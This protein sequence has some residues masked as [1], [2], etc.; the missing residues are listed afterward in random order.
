[1][2]KAKFVKRSKKFAL[3]IAF[4]LGCNVLS[5]G[6]M[7]NVEA[8][9]QITQITEET[10][11]FTEDTTVTTVAPE[12]SAVW[13]SI[14]SVYSGGTT[15]TVDAKGNVLNLNTSGNSG[16]IAGIVNGGRKITI[17]A[18]VLNINTTA[19]EN[20]VA[21]GILRDVSDK[22]TADTIINA[23][24]TNITVEG[25]NSAY[26]I[27][28]LANG[29]GTSGR[30][31]I[32][33][34][35]ALN[36]KNETANENAVDIYTKNAGIFSDKRS[37]T[38]PQINLNGATDID[39]AG[40]GIVV[41]G[42]NSNG[43]IVN[44]NSDI[45]VNATD[46]S[47]VADGKKST[48][49]VNMA[50]VSGLNA[51]SGYVSKGNYAALDGDI[52]VTNTGVINAAI[53]EGGY[54]NGVIN[55]EGG[56]VQLYIAG[57]S[58]WHNSAKSEGEKD[59]VSHV[60]TLSGG[61]A[62]FQAAD[63]ND[64]NIDKYGTSLGT[65]M[66]VYYT[67]DQEDPTN[68][69]GGNI[70]ITKAEAGSSIYM[71]TDYDE[72]MNT[73]EA[74]NKVLNALANKLFYIGYINST[75]SEG[76]VVE[77]ERNLAGYAQIAEGLTT[78]SATK[79]FADI[80]FDETTG[81]GSV[82]DGVVNEF[83]STEQT[84]TEFD[85]GLRGDVAKNP[86]Y[87][88]DGLYKGLGTYNFTKDTTI[89]QTEN[90]Y[91]VAGPWLNDFT[92][93]IA[94]SYGE[95]ALTIDMNG[96]D[97]KV[98]AEQD[99]SVVGITAVGS[100]K[101]TVVNPGQMD[102]YAKGTGQTAAL[103]AN[104]GGFLHIQNGGEDLE[105]K[106][107]TIRGWT[108][109]SGSGA[110]I[111]T[112]NGNGSVGRSWIKVDGLVDVYADV[113]NG[114]GAGEAVSAVASTIE[115]GGGKIITTNDGTGETNFGGSNSLAIRAY[116]EFVSTN[117]G[118]VNVNV[119]KDA[120][121]PD[122]VATGAGNNV[123]QIVGDFST[124]GGMG[125]NGIINVGLNTEDSYWYGDYSAGSGFGVTPGENGVLNLWMGNGADWQGYT[126]Y[127]TRLVMDSGSTW[128][129]YSHNN[130]NLI[131]NLK[132]DSMWTPT[133]AGTTDLT[134]SKVR[135]FTGDKGYIYM[136]DENAVDVTVGKFAGNTTLL[137]EHDEENNI[138]GG[139]FTVQS[140]EKGSSITLMTDNEGIDVTDRE[141]A[142]AVLDEL[143]GKL[144]YTG[145]INTVNEEDESVIVGE[146]NLVGYAKIAE[147][148]TTAS[149]TKAYSEIKFNEETGQGSV[150]WMTNYTQ[151][152][153]SFDTPIK[154]SKYN[155]M[156]YLE[157][158]VIDPETDEYNFT[159]EKTTI[160][161]ENHNIAGGPW[162]GNIG[163]VI[164]ASG[165]GNKTVLN[166]DGNDLAV[167]GYNSSH[168]T[169]ITAINKGIVEVNN[170]GEL[171]LYV[172]GGGQTA[173]LF[174]NGG[175]EI[176]IHNGGENQEDKVVKITGW[177]S[178]SG[179]GALI[180]T[181]NGAAGRSWIKV[182][183]LVDVHADVTNGQGAGEAVSAVAS[184][185]DIGGGRIIATNDGT[186]ETNFGGSN[187]LAIRAYGEFVTKNAG[188][189]N[190]NV[191]KEADTSDAKAIGAGN[192]TTQIVGDFSTTGG[193]G[194]KGI[195]N[196]GLNTADSYWHGDYM[197]GEGWGV[198][199]GEY[200]V[201][202]LW[203]GN[204]AEWMGY[205]KFAT[206]LVMDTG[207]TWY[208]YAHNNDNLI[209]T[210]KNGAMWTPT[211]AG[212]STLTDTKVRDFTGSKGY[213]YMSDDN[214]V[215][216]TVGK[217]AGDTTLF[218]DHAE[219]NSIIGGN[220][221]VESAEKGSYITLITDNTGIDTTDREAAKA[222]L[223]ELAGKLYYTG[224]INGTDEE[225]GVVEGERNLSG[226]VR[227]AEGLTT[228]SVA[229]AFGGI[230]YDE[231]TG[232]GSVD[233]MTNYTQTE[234]TYNAPIFGNKDK[235]DAFIKGGLLN[236]ETGEYNFLKEQTTIS[237]NNN[238]IAGGPWLGNIGSVI[239]ASGAG[240]KTVLNLNGNDL[241]VNGY[242]SSHST[243]ITAINKG[244]VE[245]N[246]PGELEL[247]VKGGGQ[248]A[249]LFANGGGEIH[250]HNG[251]VNQED[252]VVK[253]T[254]WTSS[255]SNG[256]LIKTMNGAA[257]RSWIQIDGLVDVRADVTNGQ[258]AGEAVS[259]VA[260][261]IDIGGGR[262]IAT[263]D[264]TGETNFGGSN[265]LAIRAYGEFVT[266]NA[267]IVN[268]N[269]VKEADTSDAKAIGAG[270]NTTQI[271]GDFSTTG[272]MGTKGIIN[273]GLNTADSYWHGDYMA[274]EGWGV[275]P[276]EYGVLNLW[277]GNGA[278]W[279]GY[280]KF[281]TNLVMDTGATW[282]GY[283]HNNDN[284]IMTL[285]NGAMWTPTTAGTST[286]TDTK[287]RD[288]TGATGD[289][290]VGSI[291]MSDDNAVN[292]TVGKFTGE[293]KLFYKH[294]AS[295]PSVIYGG[296]F[297][298]QS[299]TE[300]SKITLVTD[301]EGIDFT[302][303]AKVE[304]VLDN[305]AGKLFY[306]GYINGTDEEGGVIEGERNLT[307]Y[308]EIAE[309]LTTA[310]ATKYTGDIQFS[311]T[312]GQGGFAEGTLNPEIEAPV[313]P[314]IVESFNQGL[315]GGMTS[316]DE[317]NPYKDVIAEDGSFNFTADESNIIATNNGST[318]VGVTT[319]EADTKVNVNDKVLNIAANSTTGNAFGITASGTKTDEAG[320][321]TSKEVVI[322]NVGGSVISAQATG[323][324]K[325]AAALHA[326]DNGKII[327]NAKDS[328]V[329]KMTANAATE[330]NANVI[331]AQNGAEV[332]V[333]GKVDITVG[334]NVTEAIKA[335]GADVTI[336][337]GNIDATRT[338][339]DENGNEE[340]VVGTAI[341]AIDGANVTVKG[342][343]IGDIV[344]A[345]V[346]PQVMMFAMRSAEQPEITVVDYTVDKEFAGNYYG[347][348]ESKLNLTATKGNNW[349]G[350]IIGAD[351]QA[352]ITLA[353]GNWTGANYA[354]NVTLNISNGSVWTNT[355]EGETTI[356]Q[357]NGA[358]KLSDAGFIQTYVKD[359]DTVTGTGDI[360]VENHKGSVIFN[361][362]L[363]NTGNDEAV[364][365][366]D[367]SEEA[368]FNVVGGKVTINNANSGSEVVVN[369]TREF[370]DE[371]G[372]NDEAEAEVFA[373]LAE[374]IN[375]NKNEVDNIK[376]YVS[377][378]EGL[379]ARQAMMNMA[380]IKFNVDEATDNA[381]G[382][383]DKDNFSKETEIIYGDSE[384][385]MMSGA[386]SAMVSSAMM[387][388]SENN[389]LMKR[390]GDLRM[391]EGKHG[392]WAKYYG[393]KYS[394]D[395]QK[396]NFSTSYNAYQV[397][398][399]REARNG[400][401]VG[402]AMSYSNGNS[403]Y[404]RGDGDTSV[405]S[406]GLYGSWKDQSGQYVDLIV[407][408]SKLDNE[409]DI[410]NTTGVN[411]D[412]DYEA[413]GTSISAEYGKRIETGKGFFIDPSVEITFGKVSG[414]EYNANTDYL[415]GGY[416]LGVQQDD[417]Y[418]LIGRAGL[419]IGQKLDNASYYAK[420]ALAKEFRGDYDTKY[421]TIKP[422]G[423]A[424]NP[425]G[426]SIDLGGT[427][428]ELQ[429]GG[430][431]KLSDNSMVYAS[432]ER[433]F[434]GDVEQKW[435]LDAG[436]RWAF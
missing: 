360:F 391:A 163:S 191:V 339:V 370:M 213:I 21:Y 140:A 435:R 136:S 98:H 3:G 7:S 214:A 164:S 334:A 426:T 180:K 31:N 96:N 74:Q 303:V 50:N 250:I 84:R 319:G 272:G 75:D 408:R 377:I 305:L 116:G 378:A 145:Y 169:G 284:L 220:F 251:G 104:G 97:L 123:T 79:Y 269:V 40:N 335:E 56:T 10:V 288:F 68:I 92:A 285:K 57:G 299:A 286:L 70:N 399:D 291:Y 318:T 292:V 28:L 85:S 115:L 247:Y 433:S 155:E 275:T 264:G 418:S 235:E 310:S 39:V 183:G 298:V 383:L 150:D 384:T 72:N 200:G 280:T 148:L 350:N 270:N 83:T 186:G 232:Q 307:G 27:A 340:K 332:V 320:N 143:A 278:E 221:T 421:W 430:T 139:N 424:I 351:S 132:N 80:D 209:M 372:L 227:I 120:D 195:I 175:G 401:I 161:V 406:L 317:E 165:E 412:S 403:S 76:G 129:G 222:V 336:A 113:T 243:G 204:G 293:T 248:T 87:V 153:D 259:A 63:S 369:T 274:G 289:D 166:L 410:T 44:V 400:W 125:T 177:T 64:I 49:N 137:Y 133:N 53:D 52:Y 112:M 206:N 185:I 311:E 147:G 425:A 373:A 331:S 158:G 231:V 416:K 197:A 376:G 233:W 99:G 304:S 402:G 356:S 170:P 54:F 260:S 321:E 396:T 273:V 149:V 249:A 382:Y 263:N 62:I 198:T 58:E 432:Y 174:A 367:G 171:E 192:N 312:T 178:S 295:V 108:A 229:K 308:V 160:T 301:A 78:S 306:T 390:M 179:N 328:G 88:A 223:E 193:M 322:E 162:L 13:G 346:Q 117:Y 230:K 239:S 368:Q 69:L 314:E 24:E 219:D 110:L 181:M 48:I 363:E 380:S 429:L 238:N 144:Y 182:D 168:S 5:M 22:K 423:E 212:T 420:F 324:G 118:I 142:N 208:G 89:N 154:G 409:F 348:A 172:K 323:N 210:L 152:S 414:E 261:T 234:D 71:I 156:P 196:V 135:E 188:I 362:A 131:M 246:N 101:V 60:N 6:M 415:S 91:V 94:S 29:S 218:Y 428:F 35:G 258:G 43:T 19:T 55:N 358:A 386:K 374:Q 90:N 107:V 100:G 126:A 1:M 256:A 241:A 404:V 257:G 201:L 8:A 66:S 128:F 276:G 176:H 159:Q 124:T 343:I 111:K 344:T 300:G 102:I 82:V 141:L 121:A 413:W 146:R 32:T 422:T 26:G 388:R 361:Y 315:T 205:T 187:S 202:N 95:D 297:T 381:Q 203:M 392:I 244:I 25:E 157:G 20:D 282:Y 405:M 417:F 302:S 393:G 419:R 365:P 375:V 61:G 106:V 431:A 34:N 173:A 127:A 93:G 330:G 352:N 313:I 266:K 119:T 333:N 242:N 325:Q 240:N 277:M 14:Q 217:F 189:V 389:D 130:D 41:T 255:S 11:T 398:Y 394:M 237:A 134:S 138:I 326:D 47:L 354:N 337:N 207:A 366:V 254:G 353:G 105:D 199:P 17:D 51:Y 215:N 9:E 23:K 357:L 349:N 287:V 45:K 355:N 359:G 81:Q 252:K 228:A 271:V 290:A 341:K 347:D 224:Y 262:I 371:C 434:G 338:I 407:K 184:T 427:W 190:V 151:A 67:H 38:Q 2:K 281:A 245:V 385:A 12:E 436:L 211:T 46:Y 309:G 86:D 294:D 30:G 267:G 18:D 194:T 15:I 268:V 225:G 265:S 397:G 114:Q 37:S 16:N 316:E 342:K 65:Y 379:T 387:W 226:Q 33:I 296:N 167:N 77:G 283:A 42:S 345:K 395:A 73:A 411:L 109:S 36:I 122:A 103:F 364:Q 279:M 4:A 236:L 327:I 253:I 329:I 59:T 216:V